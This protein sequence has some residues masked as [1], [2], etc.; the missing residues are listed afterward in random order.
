MQ[1]YLPFLVSLL[2]AGP[3]D[4]VDFLF[5]VK[6]IL[7]EHCYACHGPDEQSRKAGLRLDLPAGL[8]APLDSG[9]DLLVP[10][11]A[12][13]SELFLRI[14]STDEARVM[15]PPSAK[16]PLSAEQIAIVGR[17]IDQGALLPQKAHW[18][19]NSLGQVPLPAPPLPAASSSTQQNPIDA[20]VDARLRALGLERRPR[21]SAAVLGRRLAIDLTGLPLAPDA[22][23]CFE[24]DFSAEAFDRLV[25]RLLCAPAY[26]ERMAVEWL[27]LARY[28][29]TYGYQADVD[30]DMSAW[31]D[32]VVSAFNAGMPFDQFLTWQIAGDLLPNPTR[33]Q[34]LATAFNRLH[35]QT[36]EGGSI[37]EE[38]RTEYV[39][40]RVHTFGTA[41]LGLSLECARC[42]DHKFDPITQREYYQ[43]FAFFNNIDESGLYSHFTRATPT[44]ALLLYDEAARAVHEELRQ[45]IE[46]QE[47]VLA[48]EEARALSRF[49]AWLASGG[50]PSP[51]LPVASYAF[52]AIEQNKSPN[53]VDAA[54][55]ALLIDDPLLVEGRFAQALQ[56]S[57]DN[58]AQC[59]GVGVFRRT[60]PFSYSLW[61]KPAG[62]QE[63]AVVLHRSRAWT[64]SGS[65]G[66]ELL[67]ERGIPSFALIHFYP[68]NALHARGKQALE[69]GR[70]SHLAVTYDG[71]SRAAGLRLYLNGQPLELEVVRDNLTRD[72]RHRKEWGDDT[73]G[74]ELTLAG[75][76]RDSG[77]KGGAIDE[78]MVFDR[79]LSAVE[80]RFLAAGGAPVQTPDSRE[81]LFRHFVQCVD[82]P[83]AQA[84]ALLR[85]LREQED[86]LVGRAAEIMI[87]KELP[88]RRPTYVL[89]RGQYNMPLDP[90][91]P[92]TP[93]AILE[94]P[95]GFSPNRLGLAQ[96]LTDRRNPLVARVVVN[97][98]WKMH[99]G[100]GL[101]ATP[102]DFGSQGQLPTHPELLDWLAG[103]FIDQ[104]WDLKAL[105]R[106]IVGSATY[107]QSSAA[108]AEAY[109]ADPDNRW[110]SRGPRHRLSAEQL[111]DSALAVSGLLSPRMGGPSVK[112]Y[113]P[114][115]LWEESGTGKTYVQDHGEAL[116]RRS[117][118]TFWRRTAPPPTMVMFDATPRE[119]C[120]AKRETTATPLQALV[121]LN[122]PQYLEAARVL[123]ERLVRAEPS[124]PQARIE[125]AFRLVIGRAARPEE[126]NI[127]RELYASQLAQLAA[128]PEAAGKLASVGEY[129]RD[130]A[131]SAAEVA[132]TAIVVSTCMN[133]DEFVMK[134]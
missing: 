114:R 99:F 109:A 18:A 6:P 110:L 21:A 129:P 82:E 47:Q 120:S 79:C 94:F 44:P 11:K 100:R 132:A 31:R 52:D 127:L 9:A 56:F 8:R 58:S 131:L 57:G 42:H 77:F 68:G 69:P 86:D 27:D 128:A 1:A 41:F 14:S 90:V 80:V 64:D 50:A 67:L 54:K 91:Q 53:S 124:V 98:L 28:A 113:Q 22:L 78:L 103:W 25:D 117:L 10:G 39:A 30:R 97:R 121:L 24:R 66:Y 72:I 71:S 95:P 73:G 134:R 55:P 62:V 104:G 81:E 46:A 106:L 74:V 102:E 119:V 59:A 65:R 38:F 32:W 112:P 48:R 17:W 2:A 84:R 12:D 33:E 108:P 88:A 89:K 5:Q 125:R 83:S 49:D 115:G 93:A 40:D 107:Q 96:W 70:F 85:Q 4:R 43:L 105:H 29:D 92:G 3:A 16:N 26:G 123:A 45:R 34:Y 130:A 101:V 61:V 116:Y 133:H 87:M 36:N 7:A 111:R 20:F 15:P 23:E 126:L 76:F 51:P 63:R 35:R 122:D 19:F 37:E 60:D 13:E 75:R 118:Y